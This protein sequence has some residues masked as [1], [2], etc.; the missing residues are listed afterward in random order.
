MDTNIEILKLQ[1][2]EIESELNALS[3][4]KKRLDGLP[5]EFVHVD[6][7]DKIRR[8]GYKSYKTKFT[9]TRMITSH[10]KTFLYIRD[11]EAIT[12]EMIL[13]MKKEKTKLDKILG[14]IE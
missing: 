5:L 9:D 13:S 1:R 7:I 8:Y 11:S 4:L 3:L 6:S 12:S 2:I 14:P 10:M